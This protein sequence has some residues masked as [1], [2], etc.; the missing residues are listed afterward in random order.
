MG[1]DVAGMA[2]TDRLDT[3]RLLHHV[4]MRGMERRK[5]FKD[6][7]DWE[8]FIERLSVLLWVC[9]RIG[10]VNGGSGEKI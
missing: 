5:I 2:R 9:G 10:K 8:D 6:D 7:K 3:P 1:V 4:T